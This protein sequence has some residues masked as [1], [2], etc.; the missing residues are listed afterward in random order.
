MQMIEDWKFS[1]HSG[2]VGFVLII[3][4][5]KAFD[6]LPQDK[7][8][9]KFQ[10]YGFYESSLKLMESY[11]IDHKQRVVINNEFSSWHHVT[12]CVQACS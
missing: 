5:S 7:I 3:D 1:L 9:C 2:N 10:E 8:I 12:L 6:T 4:L 11:L